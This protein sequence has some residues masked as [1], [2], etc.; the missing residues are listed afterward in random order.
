MNNEKKHDWIKPYNALEASK[1]DEVLFR[2]P[3]TPDQLVDFNSEAEM[4]ANHPIYS[5]K[6][7]N[8]SKE[9]KNDG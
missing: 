3:L 2:L 7:E 1:R 5:K 9:K 4:I 6:I 8:K